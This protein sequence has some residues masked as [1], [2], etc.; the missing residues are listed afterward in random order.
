MWGRAFV[1]RMDAASPPDEERLAETFATLGNPLRLALLRELRTPRALREIEVRGHRADAGRTVAR[2]TVKEHLDRLLQAGFAIAREAE[3]PYGA[4]REFLVNHQALFALSE[5]V[6]DLAR[7][8][9]LVEPPVPTAPRNAASSPPSEGA[10]LV[11]V[12]GL[13][14]GV[15]FDLRPRPG[16]PARWIVGRRR[17]VAVSLDFDPYLSGENSLL[18]WDGMRHL[19]EDLPGSRNGTRVNYR[20]LEP[21]ERHPLRHGD[22]VH[23][24]GCA[25]LYWT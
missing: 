18:T 3:R 4:T 22:L 19:L 25:L 13:E 16:G 15:T 21:E 12:K 9:A 17:G 1:M 10:R 11:L 7:L 23:V 6:K 2:Q 8:R 5:Q 14:E 20:R 24:G